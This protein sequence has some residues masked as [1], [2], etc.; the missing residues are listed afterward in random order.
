M[1]YRVSAN[2]IVDGAAGNASPIPVA[3]TGVKYSKAIKLAFSS[4]FSL[5]YQLASSGSPDIQIDLEHSVDGNPPVNEGASSS[6][7]IIPGAIT[8]IETDLTN[9]NWNMKEV[10]P[11]TCVWVRLKLTGKN[12]NP[13]DTTFNGYFFEQSDIDW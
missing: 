8:S 3:S 6:N 11:V 12:A 4:Y 13:S 1:S 2:Q 5:S 10:Q 7:F 9:K